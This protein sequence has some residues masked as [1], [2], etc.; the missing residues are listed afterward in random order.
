MEDNSLDSQPN[1]TA[2]IV[3]LQRH[4][5]TCRRGVNLRPLWG[6]SLYTDVG[7]VKGWGMLGVTLVSWVVVTQSSWWRAS[8]HSEGVAAKKQT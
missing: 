7:R 5:P 3:P 4:T 8:R 1:P 2:K 6:A